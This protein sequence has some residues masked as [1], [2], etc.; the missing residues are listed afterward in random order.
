M[1][2]D[3]TSIVG[4]CLLAFARSSDADSKS[5]GLVGVQ[6]RGVG[7]TIRHLQATRNQP[8][9]DYTLRSV[10]Q[11]SKHNATPQSRARSL[12]P[13]WAEIWPPLTTATRSHLS[14]YNPYSI[15]TFTLL[16]TL[17]LHGVVFLFMG[18]LCIP[19]FAP[20][21]LRLS[22]LGPVVF[23][24]LGEL[25][26]FVS[27]TV[28]GYALAALYN[29]NFLRMS[30]WVPALWAAIQTLILVSASFSKMRTMLG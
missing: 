25:G 2:D 24:A 21:H 29:A 28:V 11:N 7:S 8:G 10:H 6:A 19:A 20:R 1:S 14:L 12:P 15:W 18:L 3:G 13:S 23:V 5:S 27:A 4:C 26:A 17:L 9:Q 16:W 22:L 30:T